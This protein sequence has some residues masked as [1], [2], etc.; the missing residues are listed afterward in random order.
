LGNDLVDMLGGG[1]P[2]RKYSFTDKSQKEVE[3]YTKAE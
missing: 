2:D 3:G 1:L